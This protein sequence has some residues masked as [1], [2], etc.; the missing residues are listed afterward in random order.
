MQITAF[1]YIILD[2]F[3]KYY[4]DGIIL[5]VIQVRKEI[6]SLCNELA[7]HLETPFNSILNLG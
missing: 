5:T 6:A 7:I 2:N 4:K 1:D 3:D